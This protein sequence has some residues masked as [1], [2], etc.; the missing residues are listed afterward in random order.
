MFSVCFNCKAEDVDFDKLYTHEIKGY[1]TLA[2][3]ASDNF[4][5]G[6]AESQTHSV[7]GDKTGYK[8]AFP[9]KNKIHL[10]L[11]T[12]DENSN[13]RL[14]LSKTAA[15]GK[16]AMQFIKSTTEPQNG[17][18]GLCT[19]WLYDADVA[20]SG[21]LKIAFDCLLPKGTDAKLNFSIYGFGH[22]FT[23]A[24]NYVV[25]Y[26]K[27]IQTKG[28]LWRHVQ[29]IMPIGK[30]LGENI[31]T[32]IDSKNN[33]ETVKIQ[34]VKP[35]TSLNSLSFNYSGKLGLGILL[36]NLVISIIE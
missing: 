2:V 6:L 36:D 4:E 11:A 23:V 13:T 31:L 10:Y 1:K 8:Y 26:D 34:Q 35:L 21:K 29:L 17:H 27:N 22:L 20:T 12:Q 19:W 15:S 32:V 14:S 30:D 7:R 25:H 18:A 3:I 16:Y 9:A 5:K 24:P 28:D 33:K